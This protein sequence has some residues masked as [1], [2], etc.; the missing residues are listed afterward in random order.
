MQKQIPQYQ[1]K[2][3]TLYVLEV[4]KGW[5]KKNKIKI[6]TAFEYIPSTN[7]PNYKAK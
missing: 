4:K 3:N 1:T 6:G 5:F 2:K 7:K